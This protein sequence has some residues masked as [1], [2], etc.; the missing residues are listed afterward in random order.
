MTLNFFLITYFRLYLFVCVWGGMHA[1]VGVD[2][3]EDNPM[4]SIPLS[5]LW[6]WGLNSDWQQVPLPAEHQCFFLNINF[7]PSSPHVP[8]FPL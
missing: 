2:K 7:L 8:L 1:I 5:T 4:K 6:S 3:S